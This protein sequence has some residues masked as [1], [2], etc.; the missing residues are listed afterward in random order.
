MTVGWR[1]STTVTLLVFGVA[2]MPLA[3][4]S[5]ASRRAT[6][7]PSHPAPTDFV[8]CKDLAPQRADGFVVVGSD[9]SGEQHAYGERATMFACV[10]PPAGGVVRLV[11]SGQAIHVQPLRQRVS[12]FPSGVVPF[13]VRVDPGGSGHI[14][15]RQDT[16]GG[17][18]SGGRG[19]TIEARGDGWRFI[20]DDSH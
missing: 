14:D 9:W 3:G 7:P 4:C 2:A 8:S 1:L 18:Y 12:A 19:P 13:R 6:A 11:V 5:N 16:A 10:Y 17:G 20:W 15:V